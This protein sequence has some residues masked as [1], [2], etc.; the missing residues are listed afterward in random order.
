MG[1]SFD[2]FAVA[3]RQ[4]SVESEFGFGDPFAQLDQVMDNDKDDDCGS[5]DADTNS[6]D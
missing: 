4:V 2:Q 1:L 3:S 5:Q 6:S